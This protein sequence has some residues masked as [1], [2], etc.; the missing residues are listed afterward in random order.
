MEVRVAL[1]KTL[2]ER[3]QC[4]RRPCLVRHQHLVLQSLQAHDNRD[5]FQSE[6]VHQHRHHWQAAAADPPASERLQRLLLSWRHCGQRPK[7]GWQ[8]DKHTGCSEVGKV[9]VNV[10]MCLSRGSS[11][12]Y[13]FTQLFK[14]YTAEN[15]K[16]WILKRI[17]QSLHQPVT[18][19]RTF[20]ILWINCQRVKMR[21]AAAASSHL[22]LDQSRFP[23]LLAGLALGRKVR[24]EHSGKDM[25]KFSQWACRWGWIRADNGQAGWLDNEFWR[26]ANICHDKA[27]WLIKYIN[28]S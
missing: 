13:S 7:A 17:G 25:M 27:S 5:S 21:C 2:C 23:S 3:V 20:Y 24:I 16:I 12:I 28:V 6:S 1:G 22:H 19:E 18:S 4:V 11:N 26:F 10:N 9:S 8:C 15:P 14:L